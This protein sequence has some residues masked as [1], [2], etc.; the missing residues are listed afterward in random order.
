M[1]KMIALSIFLFVGALGCAGWFALQWYQKNL[2]IPELKKIEIE[3]GLFVAAFVVISFLTAIRTQ[4]KVIYCIISIML[5]ILGTIHTRMLFK[6]QKIGSIKKFT[7]E[8]LLSIFILCMGGL[9]F[10]LVSS[11]WVKGGGIHNSS[12]LMF[13]LPFFV[14]LSLVY[15]SRVPTLIPAGR[16]YDPAPHSIPPRQDLK[17]FTF[18]ILNREI[19]V[20]VNPNYKV[21]WAF[22]LI[23]NE[24]LQ[25]GRAITVM[26]LNKNGNDEYVNWYFVTEDTKTHRRRYVDPELTFYANQLKHGD[27]IWVRDES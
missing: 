9:A 12:I 20:D 2:S 26:R 10:V 4:P 15:W 24:A 17:S 8:S 23:I 11:F 27:I 1:V 25:M 18:R 7:Q 13:S 6:N 22:D 5:L 14:F 16:P 19:M 21:G 3:N